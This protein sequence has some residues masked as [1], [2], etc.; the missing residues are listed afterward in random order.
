MVIKNALKTACLASMFMVAANAALADG[1]ARTGQM[2][3][4]NQCARC[5]GARPGKHTDQGRS[6][7]GVVG[8]KAGG[9]V[10]YSSPAMRKSG[11]TWT[12]DN[13]DKYLE[14]PRKFIP[15]NWMSAN[16]VKS[17]TWQPSKTE[18][19]DVIAFLKE[20]SKGGGAD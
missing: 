14:N 5:H 17:Y 18:R 11:I 15:G 2:L 10:F 19:D 4:E 8:R 12:G 16:G 13:L 1:D 7:S 3:F 6:L 20:I 9:Y